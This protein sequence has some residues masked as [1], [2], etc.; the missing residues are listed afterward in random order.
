MI[1]YLYLCTVLLMAGGL[2]LTGCHQAN[3]EMDRLSTEMEIEPELVLP[4]MHGSMAMEDLIEG[5]DSNDYA[6][7]DE[8]GLLYY[9]IFADTIFTVDETIESD[10]GDSDLDAFMVEQLKI[11]MK[12]VNQLPIKVEVQVYLEDENNVVL[13]SL[14]DNNGIILGPSL[15]DSD[16][17]LIEAT[18]DENSA[19][20]DNEKIEV[21]DDVVFTRLS[22]TMITTKGDEVFVKIYSQHSLDFEISIWANLRLNTR[23]LN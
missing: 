18:E 16:G 19:S 23:D 14:F 1:R 6:L 8:D 22:A 11:T 5:V 4:L 12:T 3:F 9:L 2:L 17:K 10:F 7:V 21:L 13:D 15:T 20:F